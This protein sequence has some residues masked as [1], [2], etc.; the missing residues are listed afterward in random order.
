MGPQVESVIPDPTM[1]AEA[2]VVVI[3]GGII[4]TTGSSTCTVLSTAM[5]QYYCVLYGSNS[6]GTAELDVNTIRPS[7][8]P[9]TPM[10]TY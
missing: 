10:C 3:G 4:G 7:G 2:D 1:P 6:A 5:P 8:T 9:P